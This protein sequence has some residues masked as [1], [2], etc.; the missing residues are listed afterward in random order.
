MVC[1]LESLLRDLGPVDDVILGSAK[2]CSY[3]S[4]AE[5]L[6]PKLKL[7]GELGKNLPMARIHNINASVELKS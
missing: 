3:N 6:W 1:H 4:T 7:I 2:P 5:G